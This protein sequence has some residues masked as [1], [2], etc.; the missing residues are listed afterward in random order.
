MP[1]L[2]KKIRNPGLLRNGGFDIGGGAPTD[3]VSS[4]RYASDSALET[5]FPAA[6]NT[7]MYALVDDGSSPGDFQSWVYTTYTSA[8]GSGDSWGDGDFILTQDGLVLRYFVAVTDG[9]GLIPAFLLSKMV[10]GATRVT[11][12]DGGTDPRTAESWSD[13]GTG[14]E[15]TD[16]SVVTG[17][18]LTTANKLTTAGSGGYDSD[19]M[20]SSSDTA[21]LLVGNTITV[22]GTQGIRR[23]AMYLSPYVG[24]AEWISASLNMHIST[25]A[26]NWTW[27]DT[28]LRDTGV[29]YA[30][31]ETIWAAQN[32]TLGELH[33][34]SGGYF[35]S[36]NPS[37]IASDPTLRA[38][39]YMRTGTAGVAGTASLQHGDVGVYRLTL[40]A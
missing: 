38:L 40:A 1:V 31:G 4:D 7:D 12:T 14:I 34:S 32:T 18:G 39:V 9:P 10:T 11:G 26:T 3:F 6:S 16:Y 36:T 24:A 22:G 25:S 2:P 19:D 20:V 21:L 13:A 27:E 28:A 29:A 37:S 15:S 33:T 30:A 17:S 23:V 5:A 8:T 35:E